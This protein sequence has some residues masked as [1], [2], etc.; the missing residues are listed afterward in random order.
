MT[1][2]ERD[3]KLQNIAVNLELLRHSEYDIEVSDNED[4]DITH[5][6]DA[7]R[8]VI[9]PTFIGNRIEFR[10]GKITLLAIP[11]KDIEDMDVML[12]IDKDSGIQIIFNDNQQNTNSVTF[13]VKNKKHVNVLEQ[14][15][16]LLKDA[17]SDPFIQEKVKSMLN[18]DLCHKCVIEKYVI[19]FHSAGK[20]CQNCFDEQYGKIVLKTSEAEYVAD[21]KIISQVPSL[22]NIHQVM[23]I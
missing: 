1:S 10:K 4:R 14:Q 12:S 2:S 19:Q 9:D 23:C 22:T 21:M 20:L 3:N 13:K 11:I 5:V 15:I 8:L 17:E 16:N 7:R 18:P 6:K